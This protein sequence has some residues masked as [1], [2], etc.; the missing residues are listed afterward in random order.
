MKTPDELWKE[1]VKGIV[2]PYEMLWTIIDN[3][4]FLGYDPYYKDLRAAMID[5]A[6]KICQE[7]GR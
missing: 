1:Y 6:I 7:A 5:Q 4:G 2:D 3:E